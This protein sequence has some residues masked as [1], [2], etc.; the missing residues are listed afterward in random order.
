G[1]TR[2]SS[3]ASMISFVLMPLFIWLWLPETL[4]AM[5]L[6]SAVL[7]GRH[8]SN[9]RKL[10]AGGELGFRKRTHDPEK[11]NSAGATFGRESRRNQR[12]YTG[13]E[14]S[15]RGQRAR[16]PTDKSVCCS[17]AR[18]RQAPANAIIAP[19]SVQYCGAG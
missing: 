1:I 7:L 12:P 14:S 8:H 16:T 2:I 9:I 4:P 5:A 19:L 6:L 3:L 18:K 13:G 15:A 10:L 11:Q 17:P